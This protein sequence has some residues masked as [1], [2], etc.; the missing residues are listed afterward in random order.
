MLEAISGSRAYGLST[1]KSDTDIRGIFYLPEHQ[2][3]GLDYIEQVNNPTND[4]IFYELKRVFDLLVK[5]N[6]N[7]LELTAMP[8]DCVVN[9]HP[10]MDQLTP[11]L[12]LS[13][14]C[15]DTFAGYAKAQIYK[16]R[17]L[18]KKIVNPMSREKKTLLDFCHIAQGQGTVP[19]EEWLKEKGAEQSQ[20]GLV[21]LPH[22]HD[23]YA[24]FLD[25]KGTL[26]YSGII[27]KGAESNSVSLS[28][29][30][31]GE[32]PEA[33][34]AFNKDGYTRYCKDYLAYWDWVEKRNENRYLANLENEKNYDA[35]N[36]MHTFR[37]L[38]MAEEI[39]TTGTL[40]VRRPDRE[41]LLAIRSG[42]FEYDELLA[43]ADEKVAQI[44]EYFDR[45]DLPEEPDR[46]KIND[47]LVEIRQTLYRKKQTK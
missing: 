14:L 12:F 8:D 32:A 31:K 29:I 4:I 6:P 39:A 35:K 42:Q 33:Y 9:R 30:P 47:L 24:L 5:N 3:F 21:N 26:K 22:M 44:D 11:S 27:R 46:E 34:M 16:A 25:R 18:N 10:V 7:I 1:P 40:N 36:M 20:V 43:R 17:G 19:V 41:A 28:S 15:K 45:S 2:F 38:A 37:L 13:R 23:V